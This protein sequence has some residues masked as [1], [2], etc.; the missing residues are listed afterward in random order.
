VAV[1]GTGDSWIKVCG[2]APAA[3]DLADLCG[4][5]EGFNREGD[6][7]IVVVEDMQGEHVTVIQADLKRRATRG[8]GEDAPLRPV[9]PKIEHR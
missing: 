6:G 2:M 3:L 9:M 4:G 8:G 7:R 5:A 1:L